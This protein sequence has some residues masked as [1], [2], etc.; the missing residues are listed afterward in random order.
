MIA[1]RVGGYITTYTGRSFYPLDPQASEVHIEDIAQGLTLK[2]RW[3]G[4]CH[5]FYS[6]MSHS[7]RV[8]RVARHLAELD[9]RT[10]Q[11]S[12]NVFIYGLLH[13]AHEGYLPDIA[14]PIKR[15]I[16]GWKEIEHKV[17][18]VIHQALGLAE[19][20]QEILTYVKWA[21]LMLLSIEKDEL[22]PE[23]TTVQA[24]FNG[25][26]LGMLWPGFPEIAPVVK[27]IAAIDYTD[28]RNIFVSE[29]TKAAA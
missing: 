8:A 25:Y 27:S 11:F 1:T 15:F 21:D 28:A 16:P 24:L 6:I 20:E 22:F 13:D 19:P 14:G 9:R 10:P 26:D 5:Q 7:L 23:A 18:V 12:R 17:Q 2:C 3:T 4:Q 29:L